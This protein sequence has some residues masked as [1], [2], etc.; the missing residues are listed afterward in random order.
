MDTFLITESVILTV[1]KLFNITYSNFLRSAIRLERLLNKHWDPDQSKIKRT[2]I[3]H[4]FLPQ[5]TRSVPSRDWL[6]FGESRRYA[7]GNP[8]LDS[9]RFV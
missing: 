3:C 2:V 5:Q 1:W 7:T 4:E 6:I 9:F 8:V